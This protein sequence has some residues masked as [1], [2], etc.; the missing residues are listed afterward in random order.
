MSQVFACISA[1]FAEPEQGS[2]QHLRWRPGSLMLGKERSSR[3]TAVQAQQFLDEGWTV[4]EHISN[5]TTGFSGTLFRALRTDESR[6]ITAGELVLSLRSTEFIDDAARDN[7]A[8]NSME[9]KEKGWAFGQIAEMKKWV[10]SLYATSKITADKRLTVTGYS[11]GG[12]LA[13]AFNM[14]YGGDADATYTFNGAGV[15]KERNGVSLADTIANFDRMRQ[16]TADLGDQ[17]T[18]PAVRAVYESLRGSLKDGA[19]PSEAQRQAVLALLPAPGSVPGSVVST[20]PDVRLLYEAFSRIQI[21]QAEMARIGKPLNSGGNPN[22]PLQPVDA[23]SIEATNINY[24]LA[25]LI[26]SRNTEAIGV[27]A[28]GQQALYDRQQG[29]Y[30]FNNFHDI[31]GYTSPS[32]VANSQLHYGTATPVFI[33]D[34]PLFRGD[35]IWDAILQSAQY[36]DVKLLADNFGL[37]DFGD[38]HSLVLLVDSLSVQNT[39]AQLDPGITQSTLNAILFAASSKKSSSALGSQGKAEGDVLENVIMGL[40]SM[41]DVQIRAMAAK[42]DGGTW[43]NP[44][45]RTVL[46]DNLKVIAGSNAFRD[47]KGQAVVRA[48]SADLRAALCEEAANDWTLRSAA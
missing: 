30:T 26:A 3:F 15:G 17:F 38:T 27:I 34:Q 31:Y 44:A 37:N 16:I 48:S 35:V 43:A 42:L 25:V 28:G 2:S 5:T 1:R 14:L 46:H 20:D 23:R 19:I 24:Q 22:V 33:E 45:D 39:L 4:A 47:I 9:I 36:H 41:L 13:T 32:A 11:L 7:Q 6:G 18:N 29:P 21:I 12:H 8:T 40:A 10:D